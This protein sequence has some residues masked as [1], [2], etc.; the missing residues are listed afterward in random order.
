[1]IRKISFLFLGTT[2]FHKDDIQKC[3]I[4]CSL[5]WFVQNLSTFLDCYSSFIS[6]RLEY[7]NWLPKSKTNLKRM[8]KRK[9]ICTSRGKIPWN[10]ETSVKSKLRCDVSKEWMSMIIMV[11]FFALKKVAKINWMSVFICKRI[12]TSYG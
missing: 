4:E 11:F 6:Y 7:K 9:V 5:E 1:M 2:W 8:F 3:Y 10:A 12:F